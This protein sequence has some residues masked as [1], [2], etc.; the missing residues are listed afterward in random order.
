[1]PSIRLDPSLTPGTGS[2][3]TPGARATPAPRP[4]DAGHPIDR[5]RKPESAPGPI[6]S[7]AYQRNADGDDATLTSRANDL[8]PEETE[9]VEKLK[10][11][12]QEVRT[13]E[14]AHLA[15]AGPLA[16]GGATYTYQ[17]GPDANRYA[18]GGSVQIDTSPGN[19]PEETIA[20]AQQIKRAAL[21]PAQPS[22]TDRAVAAKAAR[23]ESEARAE[24]AQQ[25]TEGEGA[26]DP[27]A[28]TG[29]TDAPGG[30]SGSASSGVSR[31]GPA[32]DTYA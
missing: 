30:G 16:R 8:T 18:V 25:R 9:Q 6:R 11:R 29:G 12:D 3:W 24:L 14:Q 17:R 10:K 19:T 21:A 13:H 5:A 4:T 7:T 2:F 27:A 22:S 31:L 15:A 20:K 32:I 28:S 23:M 1:M 26:N